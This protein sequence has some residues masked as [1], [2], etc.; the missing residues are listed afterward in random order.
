MKVIFIILVTSMAC[1]SCGTQQKNIASIEYAAQRKVEEVG[2]DPLQSFRI[3]N[4]TS[5]R[6]LRGVAK[7]LSLALNEPAFQ[8]KFLLGQEGITI[9]LHDI[10]CRSFTVAASVL[11]NSFSETRFDVKINK[12]NEQA[13]DQ[14][15]A[16]TLIHETMHCVLLNIYLRAKRLDEKALTSIV[17][18]GLNINDPSTSFN[19]DFFNLMNEGETGSH[20]LMHR[21]FYPQM[22]CLLKRFAEIHKQKLSPEAA[23][24]LMW[25]GLQKTD[26]Y[27]QLSDEKKSDIEFTILTAKGFEIE[28]N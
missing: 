14:A 21:L 19:S 20:E 15:L 3:I 5:L 1:F 16:A 8:E 18:F 7:D 2:N 12:Y 25:S 26:A 23:E 17:N 22:V 9:Y 10:I 11:L 4:N 27:Q 28:R 24:Y 6:S 13:E